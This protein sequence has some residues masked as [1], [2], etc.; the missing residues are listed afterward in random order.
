MGA[1]TYSKHR[2]MNA[3]HYRNGINK[4]MFAFNS[5]NSPTNDFNSPMI[6]Y[7]DS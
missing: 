5:P 3:D 2:A 7:C 6:G 1:T 4:Q